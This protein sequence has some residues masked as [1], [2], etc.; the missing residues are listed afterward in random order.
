MDSLEDHKVFTIQKGRVLGGE[1]K[2]VP[3]VVSVCLQNLTDP[4]GSK[5]PLTD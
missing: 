5:N 4:D 2:P 3:D 1:R